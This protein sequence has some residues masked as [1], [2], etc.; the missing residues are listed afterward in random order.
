MTSLPRWT[1]PFF[2]NVH[3]GLIAVA[4]VGSTYGWMQRKP[5][6]SLLVA[7]FCGASLVYIADHYAR[8][9][10][11]DRQIHP[12]RIVWRGQY[13]HGVTGYSMGL[14][15]V[16]LVTL[17]QFP[18]AVWAAI[19]PVAFLSLVYLIPRFRDVLLRLPMLKL[20]MVVLG[21][22]WGGVIL[23]ATEMGVT[24]GNIWLLGLNRLLL[25]SANVW[26]SHRLDKAGMASL[27]VFLPSSRLKNGLYV[28]LALGMFSSLLQ[29][30][31]MPVSGG[32]MELGGWIG[33]GL[34]SRHP[35]TTESYRWRWDAWAG[36]PLIGWLLAWIF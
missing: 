14:L 17:P 20:V 3:V 4:W 13:F 21:W 16:L 19:A 15:G 30:V 32:W 33:M 27:H 34:T 25:I 10:P 18:A 24:G 35:E 28:F 7:A 36:F 9:S 31:W 22:V 6:L 12:E 8:I 29:Y 2:A 11:E 5:P 26:W 23:P 1:F